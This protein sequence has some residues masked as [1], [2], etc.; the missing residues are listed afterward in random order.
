MDWVRKRKILATSGFG[1]KKIVLGALILVMVLSSLVEADVVDGKSAKQALFAPVTAEVEVLASAGLP[2]DQADALEMVGGQQPYYGAIA[3]SPDEGLMSEA[4]VAAAN[5]H[6]T[7]AASAAAL[8]ECN[9]KKTGKADCVVAALIRPRGW[10][11]R[12]LQLSSDATAGFNADYSAGA[13][14]VSVATGSWGIGADDA[15]AVQV[16]TE[17]NAQTKDCSVVVAK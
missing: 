17:K 11:P 6:D 15:A 2:K 16:C 5:Y 10:A 4:T 3:I 12:A 1:M 7:D 14:A 13:L 8:A 9:A